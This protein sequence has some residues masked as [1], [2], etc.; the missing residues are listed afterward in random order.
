MPI[1][2]LKSNDSSKTYKTSSK[3]N[4]EKKI[5]QCVVISGLSLEELVICIMQKCW[6]YVTVYINE[7]ICDKRKL[8]SKHE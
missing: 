4:F 8:L 6:K 3:S 7:T 5:L 2:E 1:T